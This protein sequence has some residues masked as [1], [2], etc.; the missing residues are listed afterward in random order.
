MQCEKKIVGTILLYFLRQVEPP[1]MQKGIVANFPRHA[2]SG[3]SWED[4]GLIPQ[5]HILS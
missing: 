4:D 3:H 2:H 5:D 1:W